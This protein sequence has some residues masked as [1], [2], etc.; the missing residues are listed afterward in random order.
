LHVRIDAVEIYPIGHIEEVKAQ[1]EFHAFGDVGDFLQS[2]IHLGITGIAE[3]VDLF[4]PLLPDLR[5]REGTAV[6]EISAGAVR[7][8]SLR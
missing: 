1:V 6:V 3:L 8:D 5:E 7:E 4:V 2:C